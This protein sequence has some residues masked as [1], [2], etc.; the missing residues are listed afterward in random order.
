MPTHTDN[1]EADSDDD[2]GGTDNA[3]EPTDTNHP[4]GDQH[5]ADNTADEPPG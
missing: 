3:A 1:R 5:A 2:G 4:A